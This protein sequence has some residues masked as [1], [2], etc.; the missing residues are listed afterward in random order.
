MQTDFYAYVYV[1]F[2]P[3]AVGT[4]LPGFMLTDSIGNTAWRSVGQVENKSYRRTTMTFS[5]HVG[6]IQSSL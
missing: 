3:I 2:L 5:E 6:K 1:A 4:L